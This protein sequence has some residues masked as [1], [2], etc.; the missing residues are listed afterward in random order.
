[1]IEK[2]T[3]EERKTLVALSRLVSELYREEDLKYLV[4]RS[5]FIGMENADYL[6]TVESFIHAN[7]HWSEIETEDW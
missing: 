4:D 3:D 5:Y 1:M 6:A 2:M 7:R